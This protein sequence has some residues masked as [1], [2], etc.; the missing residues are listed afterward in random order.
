MRHEDIEKSAGKIKSSGSCRLRYSIRPS[1]PKVVNNLAGELSECKTI[2]LNPKEKIK[3][4][5]DKREHGEK[6]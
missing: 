6:P 1:F 4:V 3:L 5:L 2:Y